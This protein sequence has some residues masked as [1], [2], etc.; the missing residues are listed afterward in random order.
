M[1]TTTCKQTGESTLVLQFALQIY[2]PS[3]QNVAHIYTHSLN[4]CTNFIQN[5][6]MVATT[7]KAMVLPLYSISKKKF[8]LNRSIRP[9][10]M[11]FGLQQARQQPGD[12]HDAD[13]N[14]DRDSKTKN[15]TKQNS[16]AQPFWLVGE[17]LEE[18]LCL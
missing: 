5:F 6:Q 12:T 18:E 10:T 17:Q 4:W 15:K 11:G 9:S 2:R 3:L 13:T 16:R 1:V 8:L 14:R 7:C